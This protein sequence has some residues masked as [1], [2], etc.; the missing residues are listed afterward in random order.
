MVIA[1]K[2][3]L[4]EAVFIGGPFFAIL[5]YQMLSDRKQRRLRAEFLRGSLVNK[6]LL[7]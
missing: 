3:A 2:Q 4:V 1:I 5:A 7:R 6:D